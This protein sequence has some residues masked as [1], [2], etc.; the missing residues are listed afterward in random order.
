MNK[1]IVYGNKW[2]NKDLKDSTHRVTAINVDNHSETVT[3]NIERGQ[4]VDQVYLSME[5][6]QD[7]GI[8][9]IEKLEK[10]CK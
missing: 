3:F 10:Y 9:N 6:C 2:M 7:L 5:A 8:I 4:V 1:V